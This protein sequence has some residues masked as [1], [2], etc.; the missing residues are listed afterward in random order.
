MFNPKG[1]LVEFTIA[2]HAG[3][4]ADLTVSPNVNTR[5]HVIAGLITLVCDGTVAN[6][7]LNVGR[8]ASGGVTRDILVATGNILATTTKTLAFNRDLKM[9][10]TGYV[11]SDFQAG[12]GWIIPYGQYF[13]IYVNAGVAGDSFSGWIQCWEEPA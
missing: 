3:N 13:Q 8:R 6:R 12:A 1:R 10:P 7:V 11:G 9:A 5:L 2:A 4:T